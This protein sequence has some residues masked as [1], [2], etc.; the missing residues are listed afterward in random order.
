MKE[1]CGRIGMLRVT[2]NT[3]G[4]A[5][6]D[7]RYKKALLLIDGTWTAEHIQRLVDAGFDEV[8]YPDEIDQLV[9]AIV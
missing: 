9:A 7:L 4:A 2:T 5:V 3:S 1:L 8:Y 6:P